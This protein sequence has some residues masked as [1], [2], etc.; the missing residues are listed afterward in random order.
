MIGYGLQIRHGKPLF[1]YVLAARRMLEAGVHG[2][3]LPYPF[4]GVFPKLAHYRVGVPLAF[5]AAG[6]ARKQK[7]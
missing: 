2:Y 5:L 6:L 4:A 1:V 3:A 7:R